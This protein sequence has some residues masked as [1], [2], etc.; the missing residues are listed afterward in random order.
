[1][2]Y[3]IYLKVALVPLSRHNNIDFN[4]AVMQ[5]EHFLK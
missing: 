1:M 4:L 5:S 3:S 2:R